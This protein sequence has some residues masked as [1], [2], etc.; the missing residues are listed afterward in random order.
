MNAAR[1]LELCSLEVQRA[2]TRAL[3]PRRL[4]SPVTEYPLC[5]G[6]LKGCRAAGNPGTNMNGWTVLHGGTRG[7]ST[8]KSF[9]PLCKGPLKDGQGYTVVEPQLV[10]LLT[11]IHMFMTAGLLTFTLKIVYENVYEVIP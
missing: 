3:F 10:V 6:P 7:A 9:H 4:R 8:H 1:L 11:R 2:D 5:S